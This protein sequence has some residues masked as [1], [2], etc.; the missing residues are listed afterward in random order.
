[1]E[2]DFDPGNQLLSNR[3]N[4]SESLG[5]GGNPPL[6]GELHGR[7]VLSTAYHSMAPS[8]LV[9]LHTSRKADHREG[10]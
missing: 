2:S 4:V 5:Y 7:E 8:G 1:M 6:P 9:L 10:H 3:A